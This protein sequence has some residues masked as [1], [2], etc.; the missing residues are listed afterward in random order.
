[1]SKKPESQASYNRSR[2][3]KKAAVET[4]LAECAKRFPKG[5]VAAGYIRWIKKRL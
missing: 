3:A 1:M 4:I 5:K 2:L